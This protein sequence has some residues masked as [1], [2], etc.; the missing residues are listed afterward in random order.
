MK[1]LQNNMEK[2]S[3]SLVV[4]DNNYLT[5]ADDKYMESI[6]LSNACR[7]FY[8]S[9]KRAAEAVKEKLSNSGRQRTT[10]QKT[11]I[12]TAM[13]T[14]RNEMVRTFKTSFFN[15]SIFADG[16]FENIAVKGEIARSEQFL[17]LR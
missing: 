3:D 15:Y 8:Q 14:L 13:E 9:R 12:D 5:G 17:L 2:K 4:T 11:S 10:K 1:D 16:N 7:E 6:D